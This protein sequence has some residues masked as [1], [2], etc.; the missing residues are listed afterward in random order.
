MPD[1]GKPLEWT[2]LRSR[3]WQTGRVVRLWDP[4]YLL[5]KLTFYPQA[6]SGVQV[7]SPPAPGE[8]ELPLAHAGHISHSTKLQKITPSE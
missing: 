6:P 3:I 4:C 2:L 7:R 1:R 5:P 8:T